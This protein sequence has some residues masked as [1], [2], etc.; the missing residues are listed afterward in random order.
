VKPEK[1][2]MEQ[3]DKWNQTPVGNGVASAYSFHG[4]SGPHSGRLDVTPL[5]F[6]TSAK[7]LVFIN[8]RVMNKK[9]QSKNIITA[10][11]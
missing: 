2:Q 9:Q 6:L 3:G 11:E 7:R 8:K 4:F 1:F 5:L 10:P